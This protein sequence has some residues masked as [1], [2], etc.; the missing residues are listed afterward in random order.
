LFTVEEAHAGL[1][2]IPKIGGRVWTKI[3]HSSEEPRPAYLGCLREICN[4][5]GRAAEAN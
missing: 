4:N 5:L 3:V 2:S 1:E